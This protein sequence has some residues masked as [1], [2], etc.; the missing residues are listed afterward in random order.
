[1]ASS[2][3]PV[4]RSPI[5]P[6]GESTTIDGWQRACG[7]PRGAL[8]LC[9]LSFLAKVQ[10]RASRSGST[11][12]RLGAR[13]GVA[14]RDDLTH[15][16]VIGSGPGEWL[17]LAPQGQGT[18]LIAELESTLADVG[19]LVSVVELTHGRAL[20]RLTGVESVRGVLSKQCAVD[21]SD[22]VVPNG[23]ALRSSVASV[24]TDIVRDDVQSQRSYLLH[25]ERSSGQYLFDVLLDT[26]ADYAIEVCG[27]TGEIW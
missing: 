9:D 10:V 17:V 14:V 12:E 1:V 8:Q 11:V 22:K 20:M 23:A 24:V 4:A 25:C 26:G 21:F 3:P 13:H 19:G 6:V 16:L 18:A 5:A 2:A 15:R 7:A 27:S